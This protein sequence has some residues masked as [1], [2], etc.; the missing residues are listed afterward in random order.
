MR[1]RGVVIAALIAG[2]AVWLGSQEP[3]V[4]AVLQKKSKKANKKEVAETVLHVKDPTPP[5]APAQPLP[6]VVP[7][8]TVKDPAALA[9]LIDAE[10]DRRLAQ[11]QIRPSPRS[12]DAEF[13]RRVYLDLTGVIPTADKA[14]AFLESTDPNKR[15]KLID[16]LLADP[17]HGRRMADIWTAKLFPFD[18]ANRFVP[19]EPFHAW[20]A[21]QFNKNTPWNQLVTELI[22]AT[23]TAD[24]NPA[25]IYFLAN[26]TID[27]LTDTTTQHFLGVQLQC[28]Q[29][30]N[31]PF[32]SW[33]QIEYWGF[34]AFYSKVRADNPK[35]PKQVPDAPAPGVRELP[36]RSKQKDFFPEATKIVAPTFL[37]GPEAKVHPTEP[38]R[39]V[40]ARW[41]T[42]PDNPFFAR[43]MVNRLW[44]HLFAR[45]LV[46]PVDDM[47]EENVP[48][49]P[50]LLDA[51]ARHMA[52]V[53]GFDQKYL[54]KAICLSQAYQRTSRP[55]PEN[56]QDETLYSH[57]RVKV[58]TPEQL[59]DSLAQV[60]GRAAASGA[61]GKAA[62]K[63]AGRLGGQNARAQFVNFFLAGAEQPSITSYEAGIPQALRLM[64]ASL[65]NNPAL[66]RS[67]V[68]SMATP[69]AV[70]IERLYLATLSRRPTATELNDLTAYVRMNGDPATAYS[71]ILW[72]LLNS[73]EF[74]MV[75]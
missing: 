25:V 30:H 46:M 58:M 66:V 57:M 52:T 41:M 73:S 61:A 32:S 7:A 34:A 67:L 53:G 43:A 8:P 6:T 15:E 63:A 55:L 42:A 9:R 1:Y 13:L 48:T 40:L 19:K 28:A 10:V 16:E 39:P 27:R 2:L 21:E 22:T 47:L 37:G 17:N 72:A 3:V 60:V 26:R 12:D 24:E 75:R 38:Y 70:A 14:R 33:K 35:N 31:H 62:K 69:P 64:N 4:E 45:G 11:A 54:L 23:G 71:D 44:A 74:T 18:S 51:L 5:A 36:S 20:L 59:Y 49:H 65:T 68:G 50:E 29:C 56:K